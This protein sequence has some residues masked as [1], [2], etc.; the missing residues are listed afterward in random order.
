M[1]D[2]PETRW[3]TTIDGASIAYQDLGSAPLTVVLVQGF[4][5]HVEV[6]W[7]Y[8]AM[9]AWFDRLA[10]NLRVLT[11][12]KRGTGMS[13]RMPNAPS[14]DVQMDDVRAVMDAAQVERAGIVTTGNP[15][16]ALAVFFAATHPQR[17]L[18]LWIDGDISLAPT[19]DYPGLPLADAEA[20]QL[21]KLESAW[22]QGRSAVELAH[23]CMDYADEPG[24]AP[25][26]DP[27]FLKWISK[28]ARYSATP[29][30]VATFMDMWLRTD[31]RRV[32]PAITVPTAIA[33]HDG[34]PL[35][36]RETARYL[37][38]QIPGARLTGR[39]GR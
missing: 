22:G 7:E 26:E 9:A 37:S 16:P 6:Y 18:A 15:G 35:K 2:L 32:L 3:A 31:V 38:T 23:F 21:R 39:R 29:T 27:V 34:W 28:M 11:F 19:E 4:L 33:Y 13:D 36:E 25:F 1:N 10:R 24:D 17:T 5:S 12:D 8:P 30:S 20:R 14:L